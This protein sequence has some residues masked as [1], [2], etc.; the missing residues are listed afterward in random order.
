MLLLSVLT[1]LCCLLL[2]GVV[3]L[4]LMV[5]KTNTRLYFLR[6]AEERHS[7]TTQRDIAAVHNGLHRYL[8]DRRF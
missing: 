2:I 3:W 7:R 1:G 5:D 8:L 4:L 6:E